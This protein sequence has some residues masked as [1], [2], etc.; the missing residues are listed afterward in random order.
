MS[1]KF[2][3]HEAR[4][5][6]I[7]ARVHLLLKQPFWGYLAT[8][9][10]LKDVTNDPSFDFKT[11]ATD[12]KHLYYNVDFISSLTPDELIFLVAHEVEHVVYCHMDRLNGRNR[13]LW[14][15]AA[16]FAINAEL[17]DQGIGKMPS[18]GLYDTKYK[19]MCAEEIY[20]VLSKQGCPYCAAEKKK[21]KKNNNKTKSSK[22]KTGD[23][24][25][26]GDKGDNGD[27]DI[28]E[29]DHGDGPSCDHEHDCSE[30]GE[31]GSS[32]GGSDEG[33]DV[34]K[35]YQTLDHHYD[36]DDL[37]LTDEEKNDLRSDMMSAVLAAAKSAGTVPLGIQRLIN[38]YTNPRMDWRTLLNLQVT[39]LYKEDYNWA[40]CS[41]KTQ[42][43]GIYLPGLRDSTSVKAAIAIDASG[44]M[45]NDMLADL[46]SEIAGIM[47]QFNEFTLD[48]W[49]FDTQV[50]N[51]QVFTQNNIDEFLE[52]TIEGGGGTT[53]QCNWDYMR[54]NDILPEQLVVFTD[55]YDS[56][57]TWGEDDYC[58][59]LFIIH[60]DPGHQLVNPHGMIAWYE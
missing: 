46:A 25:D 14:N 26:K 20:D 54:E 59:T 31:G 2:S 9:L 4:E 50:Y 48:V 29:H 42:F 27:N 55:G 32:E 34:C 24:G 39:S 45:S 41:R 47:G 53:F 12:G 23:K 8:R 52:Y 33:G 56:S 57:D 21:K 36:I 11:A 15:A 37:D 49:S 40:R 17:V 35:H 5:A 51:H 3:E 44:S 22:S 18:I 19:G 16:D 38:D 7:T 6:L 60:S 10:M 28:D 1:T 43:S 58:D 13:T 30:G